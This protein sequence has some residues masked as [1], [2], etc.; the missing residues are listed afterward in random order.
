MTFSRLLSQADIQLCTNPTGVLRLLHKLGYAVGSG[1]VALPK[2]EIGFAP[3]DAASIRF[4]YLLADQEQLLQVI[5]F[6]METTALER[7]RSLAANFLSRGG[8][9]LLIATDDYRRIIF[10]N[11]R[12]DGGK[13]KVRKLVVD[14]LHPTRH[15]L[16]V[17]EGLAVGE[18]EP[19][20]LYLAHCD[21]FDVEQV[22]TRFYREYARLFRRVETTLKE[23]NRGVALFYEPEKLHAFAQRL[24]GRVMFLYFIQ[25]KGWLAGDPRFLTNQYT[26]KA[27]NEGN[28]YALVLEPL[29]F[30]ILNRRRPNDES[31]WGSIPY[32]N[33]GLFERDYDFLLYLPNSLFDPESDAGILGFFNNY[34]FTVAEETPV[35][36]EVAVDPEMLGR[37]FENMMEEQER[38][39][40]GTFYTPRP[41]VHYM[42][43]EALLGYLEEQTRLERGLLLAQFDED[44][45]QILSVAQAGLVERAL[46]SVRVLDPAVGTGAF[47]LGVL[48]ELVALKR[49]CYRARRV[50]V[51]RASALTA[52][53]KKAFIAD[54]LYGVDIKAEAIE[55]A[56]LRLWLSLVVDLERD[57]VEPLPNLDYKLRAGN[58]LIETFDGEAVLPETPHLSALVQSNLPG[59]EVIAQQIGLGFDES[60]RSRQTLAE[61]KEQYFVAQTKERREE[62]RRRIE[63]Q[64]RALVLAALDEKLAAI[65]TRMKQLVGRGSLVNWQGMAKER[66]EMEAL[67]NR[68]AALGDLAD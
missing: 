18:R 54:S 57:Q 5:L 47:L 14:R 3:A 27:R 42:C 13:V 51:G 8:H 23:Q 1:T 48:H 32:L 65:E 24:L 26:V 33:G 22:T 43:R 58:S 19:D 7:L 38:G 2:T 29:F 40:S 59:V 12:R 25:K 21:A 56:R 9:Y 17:L 41:I 4:V 46:D 53:W 35:D 20:E 15:D 34:N 30:D 16:D 36:R 10:V 55:I 37:V 50:E 52:E 67:A 6:E 62:L 44:N 63:A 28:F 61:M 31:T 64:E 60:E 45:Q 68:Q 11:P 39:R 49:A 66:Q